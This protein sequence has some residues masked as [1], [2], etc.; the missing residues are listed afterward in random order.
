M[1]CEV[2]AIGSEEFLL[3]F[4]IFG[5]AAYFPP[6]EEALREFLESTIKSGEAGIIYIEDS[7]CHQIKDILEAR[8]ETDIPIIMPVGEGKGKEGESYFEQRN[9]AAMQKAIGIG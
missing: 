5:F 8:R 2:Y 3:P 4:R 1:I 9:R 7:Y 6:T